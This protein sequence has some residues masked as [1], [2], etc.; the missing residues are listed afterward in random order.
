MAASKP[1]RPGRRV[2]TAGALVTAATLGMPMLRAQAKPEKPALRISV[3]DLGSL[4]HLPLCIADRMGYFA[5]AGLQVQIDDYGTGA[6]ALHALLSGRADISA[7]AFKHLFNLQSRQ[8]YCTAFVVEGR[9]PQVVTA[10]SLRQMPHYRSVEDLRGKRIGVSALG[11]TTH[12]AAS[13]LL[14]RG[15]LRSSDVTFVPVS[16]GDPAGQALLAGQVDAIATFDPLV[17]RL[18]QRGEVRVISDTRTLKDTQSIFGGPMPAGCLYAPEAFV[19]RRPQTTQAVADAMVRA[20][21]WLQTASPGDLVK[22]VP[23]AFL[24]DDRALYLAAFEK[25]R[26]AISPDGLV[27]EDGPATALRVAAGFEP[28]IAAAQL[29][30]RR[31]FTNVFARRA[32]EHFEA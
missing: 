21:K 14:S 12:L 28:E 17:T 25:V 24:R 2:F 22:T 3:G 29:D 18:E 4:Y 11:A 15:N 13:L 32:K 23:A 6:A 27:A 5:A 9:A 31:T 8:Q 10:V 16:L 26:E 30:V 19:Q 7:G 20:L 1:F